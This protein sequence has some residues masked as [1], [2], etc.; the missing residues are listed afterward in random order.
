MFICEQ[1]WQDGRK[2]VEMHS[3]AIAPFHHHL[4]HSSISYKSKSL[5]NTYAN[6][7]FTSPAETPNPTRTL[8]NAQKKFDPV[9]SPIPPF[10]SNFLIHSKHK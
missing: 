6:L 8:F 2:E 9:L 10:R 3:S 7:S 1:T 5:T 4:L